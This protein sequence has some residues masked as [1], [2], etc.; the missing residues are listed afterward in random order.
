MPP[1]P[2]LPSS[3]VLYR[4]LP[5]STAL[6]HRPHPPPREELLAGVPDLLPPPHDARRRGQALQHQL[7]VP[8]CDDPPV[9]QHHGAHVRLAPDQPA[10]SLLQLEGGVGDEI[11][12]EAV[13]T[14]RLE[15]LEPRG[16][17]RLGGDLEGE[18]GKDEGP[19]C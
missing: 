14:L 4:P 1:L 12:H 10:E 17:K 2:P 8:L 3:T 16:R 9:Q 15:P 18:L 6:Y 7:P 5:S 13:Q 11:V 19:Q